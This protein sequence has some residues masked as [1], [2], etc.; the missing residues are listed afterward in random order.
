MPLVLL[1]PPC[2]MCCVCADVYAFGI[3]LW[4]LVTSEVMP[5]GNLT[6]GQILLGVS[7]GTVSC[8]RVAGQSLRARMDMCASR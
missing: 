4:Q 3:L 2:H 7:Q 1:T 8:G 6:V 5:Y